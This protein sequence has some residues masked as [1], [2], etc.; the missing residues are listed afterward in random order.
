MT[1]STRVDILA[2]GAQGPGV[3]GNLPDQCCSAEALL[4]EGTLHAVAHIPTLRCEA[5]FLCALHEPVFSMRDLQP[6]EGWF[7]ANRFAARNTTLFLR[8]RIRRQVRV[9]FK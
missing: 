8:F 1:I 5:K 2:A 6:H 3:E 9:G 7:A 4:M